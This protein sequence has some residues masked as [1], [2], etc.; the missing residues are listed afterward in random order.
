MHLPW[1]YPVIAGIVIIHVCILA[2]FFSPGQTLSCQ[3][4]AA[5]ASS[6]TP[7]PADNLTPTT[8]PAVKGQPAKATPT[9]PAK[10]GGKPASQTGRHNLKPYQTGHYQKGICPLS[11]KLE[12]EVGDVRSGVLVD[13]NSHVILWEKNPSKAYPIASLTK[14]LTSLM[15]L[16]RVEG[17]PGLSLDGTTITIT[18]DDRAY[19]KREKINGVYLDE[20]ESFTLQE[21]LKCM[22]ISSANDAAYIVG[23]YLGDGNVETGVQR[24]NEQAKKLGLNDLVFHNPHGLPID[25]KDGQRIENMGSA[26]SVAYLAECVMQFP[27]FMKWSGTARDSIMHR[28]KPFDLNSTNHLLR[29]RVPGVNGLKTGFTNTAGYCIAVSCT[30]EGRTMLLVLMGVSVKTAAPDKGKRRDEIARQLLDWAFQQPAK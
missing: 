5:S 25:R 15:L 13:L 1:K 11:E 27:E 9:T 28:N 19:F 24:M 23:K 3:R 17:T 2:L 7:L 18:K 6:E 4:R 22:I 20:G 14:M 8:P 10:G 30:R 26:I 12:K 16:Q 29:N 21:Y